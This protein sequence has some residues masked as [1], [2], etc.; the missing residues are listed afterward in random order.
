[1]KTTRRTA[2]TS[3]IPLI[4]VVF[5]VALTALGVFIAVTAAL[6]VPAR[7]LLFGPGTANRISAVVAGAALFAAAVYCIWSIGKRG[8]PP[9]SGVTF[10]V[11]E[12]QV[13]LSRVEAA[14]RVIYRARFWPDAGPGIVGYGVSKHDAITDLFRVHAGTLRR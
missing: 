5:A 9:A 7:W 1:M 6:P 8:R 14:A 11:F 2:E 13:S 3:G 4:L 12:R 10:G